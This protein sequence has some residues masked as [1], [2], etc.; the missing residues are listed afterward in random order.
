M[1]EDGSALAPNLRTLRMLEIISAAESPPTR[2]DLQREMDLSKQ[3]VHRLCQTLEREGF[4]APAASGRGWV[5]AKRAVQIG[6]GLLGNGR[7]H[8]A[9]HQILMQL[10][11]EIGETV[12]FVVPEAEG[13]FY[14]DRVEADWPFRVQLPVG[15]HVPFHCTASG[16]VYL[17]SLSARARR[18]M[19][20][21]LDMAA[22]TPAT[23]VQPETLLE[24][25]RVIARDGFALDREELFEQMVAI[26]VPVR[27]EEGRYIASL[28]SHGPVLRFSLEAAKSHF[29]ALETAAKKLADVLLA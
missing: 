11:R 5:P 19:V 12:N 22:H 1:G 21:G 15:S 13:M 4:V 24:E 8:I 23:H 2:A 28:A 17:A 27:D 10:S 7:F 3:T 29:H 25:L 14:L 9:R 16:K 18:A 6:Q 26:A 20:S